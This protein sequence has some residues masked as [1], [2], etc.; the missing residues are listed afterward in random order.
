MLCPWIGGNG[1]PHSARIDRLAGL[2]T[3]LAL[4]KTVGPRQFTGII[5]NDPESFP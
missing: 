5:P 4:D 3:M 2:Y 1:L